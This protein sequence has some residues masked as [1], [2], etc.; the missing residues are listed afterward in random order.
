MLIGLHDAELEHIK[1][2]SFPNYALMKISAYHKQRGDTVELF[3][4]ID[5]N[6]PEQLTLMPMDDYP[7]RRKAEIYDTVYSSKVLSYTPE[8]PYLPGRTIRGGTGYNSKAE[9]APEID[10]LFPDYSIYPQCDYAIGFITRG[11]PNRCPWCVVPDKEGDIHPYR[12]WRELVRPDS[13]KIV[14]MDNNIL[15]C[16]YGIADCGNRTRR[17]IA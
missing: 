12:R 13:K 10:N 15:A 14:L 7:A 9:L 3:T 2:K 5:P 6:E 1:Q 11:C 17:R 8:N 16:E 4:P